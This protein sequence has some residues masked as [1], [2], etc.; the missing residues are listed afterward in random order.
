MSGQ[1][2]ITE[3]GIMIML[4]AIVAPPM[5][6]PEKGILMGLMILCLI[7]FYHRS[8]TFW[9]VKNPKVE[10]ITQGKLSILIKDGIIQLDEAKKTGV[11]HAQLFAALRKKK[12]YNLGK[13]DRMNLEACGLFSVFESAEAKAGLSLL[14]PVDSSIHQIHEY[15]ADDLKACINCGN[16]KK[17]K[18]QEEPC[19]KCGNTHWDKA[20]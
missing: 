18:Q 6:S 9:G 15:P 17:I 11:T 12:I 13:V 20:N 7:L 3:L 5:E 1:L 8:L 16:T 10:R 14:P 19:D 2:T 4:G